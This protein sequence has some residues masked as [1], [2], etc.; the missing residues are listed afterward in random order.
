MDLDFSGRDGIGPWNLKAPA[1]LAIGPKRIFLAPL[2]LTGLRSER[3]EIGAEISRAPLGG[4]FRAEWNGL[5][6]ARA[7]PWLNDV[8]LTGSGSG[9]IRL[10]ILPGELLALTGRADATGTLTSGGHRLTV[11]RS[12]LSIDGS[13]EGIRAGVEIAMKG[14]GVLHG[15]FT[16]TLPARAAIPGEGNIEA[17]YRGF[18]LALF[19]PWLPKDLDLGGVLTGRITGKVLAGGRFDLK[20]KTDLAGGKIHWQGEKK[21]IDADLQAAGLSWAWRGGLQR[22]AAGGGTE[23]LVLAGKATAAGTVTMDGER[24]TMQRSSLKIDRTEVLRRTRVPDWIADPLLDDFEG[25]AAAAR[26]SGCRRPA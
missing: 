17:D 21:E 3:L 6:L 4:Y 24:I 25:A 5:N 19:R 9:N 10:R 15:S 20:G 14:G 2:V 16:S 12:S 22:G 13:G 8:N 11:E 26:K 7:N 18:D 1:A 23:R